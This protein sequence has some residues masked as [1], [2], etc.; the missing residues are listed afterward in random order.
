M[1]LPKLFQRI[2]WTNNTTPA[3]N[4]SN[5]N[6]ISKG[7][8]DVDDRVI[9][10]A[11]TIME[12]VPEIQE[13]LE[14]VETLVS[15]PPYIGA[16]GNWYTWDTSTGAYVDSGVDAS[17]T[18]TVGT[19]TTLPAGSSATVT[20]SGTNTDPVFNFGIPKGDKGEAGGMAVDGTNAASLVTF[21]GAFAQGDDVVAHGKYAHAQGKNDNAITKHAILINESLGKT[22]NSGEYYGIPISGITSQDFITF[23]VNNVLVFNDYIS[24]MTAAAVSG[25]D[26]YYRVELSKYSLS[27]GYLYLFIEALQNTTTQT[28]PVRVELTT[29]ANAVGDGSHSEGNS[30]LAA[31]NYSHSE[32]LQTIA[33]K[34]YQHVEGKYNDNKSDTL[35]EVGNGTGDNARS[36]AFEV[37]ENGDVNIKGNIKKNGANLNYSDLEGTPTIPTITVDSTGTA[38]STGTRYQRIGVDGVY[39]A[40]DGTK[41]MEISNTSSTTYTFSNS[42]ITASSAIDVYTDTWG[43]NPS[44]VTSTTGSCTVTFA[45]AQ[46]RTVRIYIK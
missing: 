45:A 27:L 1:A 26:A 18:I 19:T 22:M 31:G 16:N 35:F 29:K 12:D 15:N 41:Y 13:A 17:I 11:G 4:A 33:A 14:E 36:N 21:D 10:L 42:D 34:E 39:T 6:A 40:I 9:E 30:T 43:D 23:Y 7:L 38:S 3:I 46:T 2:F 32:G 25:S 20:N 28:I 5:L 44:A 8:D 24:N 37:Y